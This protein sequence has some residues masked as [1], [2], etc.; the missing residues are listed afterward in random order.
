MN[1]SFVN[2]NERS[3]FNLALLTGDYTVKREYIC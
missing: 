2:K 3:N 1:F